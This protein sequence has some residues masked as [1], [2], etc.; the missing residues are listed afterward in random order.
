MNGR[1]GIRIHTV[2]RPTVE[3]RPEGAILSGYS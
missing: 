3:G 2:E 1:L